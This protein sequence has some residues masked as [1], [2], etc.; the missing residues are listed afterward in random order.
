[1]K[2]AVVVL[3]AI[4][5]AGVGY[6]AYSDYRK[7]QVVEEVVEAMSN[8]DAYAAKKWS[9]MA[10]LT[11]DYGF[12][13][14]TTRTAPAGTIPERFSCR[15]KTGT[16]VIAERECTE[17]ERELWHG[18]A[19]VRTGRPTKV[20]EIYKPAYVLCWEVVAKN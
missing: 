4:I 16:W 11:C 8:P 7:K 14:V 6:L 2:Q 18:D 5:A 15:A 10:E 3:L 19:G 9:N 20:G 13:D 17:S 1:M 12:A